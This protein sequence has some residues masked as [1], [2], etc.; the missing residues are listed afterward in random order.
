M[1]SDTPHDP[2][3]R[4]GEGPG[5]HPA[6]AAPAAP[7]RRT[8]MGE[9]KDALS[10][11]AL[12]LVT[13]VLVLQ[14]G[15]ILSYIGAFHAPKPHHIRSGVVAPARISARLTAE[16]N[17]LPGTPFRA[18]A[19]PT[20][21]QARRMILHRD[22]DAAVVVNPLNGKDRLLV[23]S[24]AGPSVSTVTTQIAQ[25][26][27][28][29]RN[30]QITVVDLRAPN[31]QDGRGLSSF[32]LVVGW[33]VGGYLAGSILGIAGGARP[34]TLQRTFVRLGALVPYAIASG[35]GGALIA[36]TV[37]GALP[38]HFGALF[39]IGTLLVFA[40][41][42]TTVALQVALDL[43]G[44]GLVIL[45]FV[46]LGNPS[47]GGAYPSSLLPPFWRDI[48]PWL[49]PGAGTTAVRNTVYFTGH[50]TTGPLWVLG[51]YAA[52]GIIVSVVCSAFVVRRRQKK[53][54]AAGAAA[55]AAA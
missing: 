37:L 50:H 46:V 16:L 28:V 21:A 52:G 25:R 14:L 15:F 33:M 10:L 6:A 8:F 47:A 19:V 27:E 23:A 5:R 41:A 45:V 17:A 42:A 55:P 32:Y 53:A 40:A 22:L 18:Q 43:A 7:P 48:G 31:P 54:L 34:A 38:G 49:P 29:G 12:I 4:P 26:I 3:H 44:I 2:A 13:G 36:G 11:R 35:L 9:M 30:R 20:E 39:G 51:V 24:A 1:P